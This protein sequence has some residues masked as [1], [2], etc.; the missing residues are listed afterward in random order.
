MFALLYQAEMQKFPL[1]SLEWVDLAVFC[2][3]NSLPTELSVLFN[4]GKVFI[5]IATVIVENSKKD[6]YCC[7]IFKHDYLTKHNHQKSKTK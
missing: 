4:I 5:V 2:G 7:F 1:F 6:F 3:Q